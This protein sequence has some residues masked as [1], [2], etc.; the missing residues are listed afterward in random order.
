MVDKVKIHNFKSIENM[1][2]EL[3]LLN[4]FI[5][6]NGAGKTNILEALGI[7]SSAVYGIVDDESLLRRGVR[8]GVPRLYK[9]SSKHKKM[10]A[11][12]GFSIEGDECSYQVSLLN[13]LD[14]PNPNWHFKTEKLLSGKDTLN[15]SRGVKN[16]KNRVNGIIPSVL[17]E[18]SDDAEV[19]KFINKIKNYAIYNPNTSV[20]RGVVP[21]QQMRAPVGL[22]GGGLADSVY[23]LCVEAKNDEF[24]EEALED[25]ISLFDWVGDISTATNVSAIMSMSVPR[26]KRAILFKDAYMREKYNR[27]TAADSSEGILYLLF[28][29]SLCLSKD[30]KLW[31]VDNV[32]QAL[33]PRLLKQMMRLIFEWLSNDNDSQMLCTAH[34]PAVLDSIDFSD[35]KVRLYIVDRNKDGLTVANRFRVTKEMIDISQEKNI[36]LSRMWTDGYLGGVPDV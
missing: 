19:G 34:N 1:E 4:I 15:T 30:I 25:I 2:L 16:S 14:K 9:T 22:L 23:N 10:S 28:I 18:L 29:M 7:I 12:I 31:A 13:P 6:A 36:P 11:H 21:D 3:G 20:L 35:D 33:N 5:G 32:D 24:I 26:T 17:S 8:P 27:L